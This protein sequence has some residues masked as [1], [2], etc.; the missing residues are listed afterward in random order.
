MKL[1]QIGFQRVFVGT[2]RCR[3]LVAGHEFF[4]FLCGTE[5]HPEGT[6]KYR[7]KELAPNNSQSDRPPDNWIADFQG[8][9]PGTSH[10]MLGQS[11]LIS[12]RYSVF[13]RNFMNKLGYQPLPTRFAPLPIIITRYGFATTSRT[14]PFT[15]C[16]KFVIAADGVS[17][18]SPRRVSE[19]HTVGQK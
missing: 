11:L 3:L 2:A 17:A 6:A 15:A 5:R 9:M 8:F 4:Q 7:A 12:T 14:W 18:C 13:L 19:R 1:A 16:H 10:I